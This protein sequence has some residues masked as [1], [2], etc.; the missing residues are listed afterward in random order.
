MKRGAKAERETVSLNAPAGE[1]ARGFADVLL[2]ITAA[3]TRFTQVT[4]FTQG[5][6]LHH[7]AGEILIRRFPAGVGTVQIDQHGRVFGHG[8]QQRGKAAQGV[9]PQH[10]VLVPHG[11]GADDFLLRCCK[12][13][14]PEQRHALLQG[15]RGFDHLLHPPGLQVQALTQLLLA[16]G[17][18]LFFGFQESIGNGRLLTHK[19]GCRMDRSGRFGSRQCARHH[20]L[21]ALPG[22]GIRLNLRRGKTGAQQEMPGLRSRQLIWG[23]K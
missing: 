13:V 2:R 7:L 11:L 6:Q 8:M 5:E 16:H 15:R 22:D 19:A 14:V 23:S 9:G 4:R 12:V 3:H 1:G 10:L 21:G 17:L 18:L 20:S